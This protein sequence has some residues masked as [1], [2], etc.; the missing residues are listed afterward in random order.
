MHK[1]VVTGA[2]GF[3]GGHLCSYLAAHGLEVQ[4]LSL[5]NTVAQI[6]LDNDVTTVIHLAG[7]AHDLKNVSDPSAYHE[8]NT[9]LTRKIYDAFLQ[10]SAQT[11][12]FL[13][14]VKAVA[15]EVNGVLTEETPPDPKTAYGISKLQAE[16]YI[17]QQPLPPGKRYFILRPCMIHGPRNKGNLTLLYKLVSKKIPWP[18]KA[19]DNRRSFLSVENLCFVIHQLL[20]NTAAPM[21]C[22]QVADDEP[23]STNEVVRIIAAELG[24]RP[25]L[26]NVPKWLVTTLARIGDAVPFPLNSERLQK[27]TE[28]YVV[29]NQKLKNTL[30]LSLPQSAENGIRTTIRS[31][32]QEI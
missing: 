9:V 26:W 8:I 27:L 21:G 32:K 24:I 7:K 5:R 16:A 30:R 4:P 12:I 2:G 17:E 25:R 18:L 13:S 14:S 10:S 11:F 19:F 22:Y 23:L 20:M 1:V 31:L 3:V 6:R 29:S 28:S 15:D